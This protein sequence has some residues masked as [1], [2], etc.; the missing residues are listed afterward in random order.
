MIDL[1]KSYVT[2]NGFKVCNLHYKPFNSLGNKVTFPIKG[3]IIIKDKPLRM[4]YQIWTEDGNCSIFGEH[5]YD[6]IEVKS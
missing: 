4:I 6:L 2:R 3:S 1:S 5:K